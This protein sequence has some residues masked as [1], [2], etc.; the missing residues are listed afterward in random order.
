MPSEYRIGDIAYFIESKWRIREVKIV[1][2][3][4]DL[5]LVR[6]LDGEGGT[7]IHESRLYKTREQAS[8]STKERQRPLF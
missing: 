2:L 3:S 1:K 8:A 4:G 6:F 7:R 5:A